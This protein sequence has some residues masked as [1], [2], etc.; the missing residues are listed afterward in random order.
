M[1]NNMPVA[2][3][4]AA[5]TQTNLTNTSNWAPINLPTRYLYP[6]P[7][8]YHFQMQTSINTTQNTL[9]SATSLNYTGPIHF[10]SPINYISPINY[11]APLNYAAPINN[12]VPSNYSAPQNYSTAI[13]YT[14]SLNYT[15]PL[16]YSTPTNDTPSINYNAPLNYNTHL[17]YNTPIDNTALTNYTAPL[18]EPITQLERPTTP[19]IDEP[20]SPF[21]ERTESVKP[22]QYEPISPLSEPTTPTKLDNSKNINKQLANSSAENERL[23]NDSTKSRQ[24]PE[25]EKA[26]SKTDIT[27][28]TK[29]KLNLI[30][31]KTDK[32]SK[33]NLE[34]VREQRDKSKTHDR[35]RRVK[36][37]NKNYEKH[38]KR[39]DSA[40]SS[41]EKVA[42]A[43]ESRSLRYIPKRKFTESYKSDKETSRADYSRKDRQKK[44]SSEHHQYHETEFYKKRDTKEGKYTKYDYNKTKIIEKMKEI[45][46]LYEKEKGTSNK[47]VNDS[48]KPS[49]SKIRRSRTPELVQRKRPRTDSGNANKDISTKKTIPV[50]NIIQP[51]NK[52]KY[53]T[54][55]IGPNSHSPERNEAGVED[56]FDL[57][58]KLS[59]ANRYFQ[60]TRHS[61]ENI[62]DRDN[63]VVTINQPEV[64]TEPKPKSPPKVTVTEKKIK[65]KNKKYKTIKFTIKVLCQDGECSASSHSDD[66]EEETNAE[67]SQND[68]SFLDDFNV[69]EIV[70]SL[71]NSQKRNFNIQN[72]NQTSNIKNIVSKNDKLNDKLCAVSEPKHD[73]ETQVIQVNESIDCII[74]DDTINTENNKYEQKYDSNINESNDCVIID[75]V[76]IGKVKTEVFDENNESY[77]RVML[78]NIKAEQ[79]V[80]DETNES[81]VI[82]DKTS[83][84]ISIKSESTDSL[85]YI[86]PDSEIKSE[87]L[88]ISN[89]CIFVKIENHPI[90]IEDSIGY[91]KSEHYRMDNTVAQDIK[92]ELDNIAAENENVTDING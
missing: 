63:L 39:F 69:D 43:H 5:V 59:R 27:D 86:K 1:E 37:E 61:K 67:R 34:N 28:K 66:S 25:M 42:N 4:S 11:T 50:K 90:K 38:T 31:K 72:K 20:N 57:R 78:T 68:L 41:K 70:D 29:I 65:S 15:V 33:Y 83:D 91:V 75:T 64:N 74:L 26:T 24:L 30:K 22:L 16:N 52:I 54:S 79:D 13:N 77:D 56:H 47:K 40:S 7:L 21:I 80:I 62:K 53:P 2:Q 82:L 32:Y 60:K 12:P 23:A 55:S 9:F 18:N 3:S 58:S 87:T 10:S 49:T 71:K 85:I 35:F 45:R 84:I 44:P 14:A 46:S 36:D 81:C 76:E 8:N 48:K 92:T 88:E 51:I 6:N 73:D 89:D 19:L 17:N